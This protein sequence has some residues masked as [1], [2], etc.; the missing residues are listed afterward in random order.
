MGFDCTLHVV[1]PSD[2][3]DAYCRLLLGHD[4]AGTEFGTPEESSRILAQ[5]RAA[6]ADESPNAAAG[7]IAQGAILF[8]TQRLPSHYERGFCLSLWAWRMEDDAML[9]AV[10]RKHRGSVEELDALFAPLIEAHPRLKGKWP[11][12]LTGNYSVGIYVPPEKIGGLLKW[13][14]NKVK[15]YSKPNR[16]LFRGLLLVLEECERRGMAYWEASDVATVIHPVRPPKDP[17]APTIEEVVMPVK[18]T[19]ELTAQVSAPGTAPQCVFCYLGD[20]NFL[21][22]PPHTACFD[23]E[24]WPP[25]M[26]LLNESIEHC[27]RARDGTWI[28]VTKREADVSWRSAPRSLETRNELETAGQPVA[29]PMTRGAYNLIRRDAPG[30]ARESV[31]VLFNLVTIV[32]ELP[33]VLLSVAGDSGDMND[34]VP[35]HRPLVLR[36]GQL[37]E[38]EELPPSTYAYEPAE[39]IRLADGGDVLVWGNKGYELVNDRFRPRFELY[40]DGW[41]PT[42]MKPLCAVGNDAILS[43]AQY[44]DETGRGGRFALFLSR[45]DAEPR[46]VAPAADSFYVLSHGPSGSV[47]ALLAGRAPK[48]LG[49]ILWPEEGPGGTLI[50]IDDELFPDEDPER[51]RSFLWS[52]QAGRLI[53][54]TE[55]RLWAVEASRVLALP[56]YDATTGKRLKR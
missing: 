11:V 32:G 28:V 13:A 36:G 24:T 42:G 27:D 55:E 34:A 18:G 9:A 52:S 14:R 50:W 49:C 48:H 20:D 44:P 39:L 6:L 5:L 45:R 12:D 7:T 21:N 35:P 22:A 37:V 15:G 46:E 2:V 19:W 3:R 8:S 53:A 33:V 29:V 17:A 56:R 23:F 54:V 10:P 31:T 4:G 16:R 26:T 47:L 30:F 41:F 51:I 38:A 43:I 40:P 1:D 25:G